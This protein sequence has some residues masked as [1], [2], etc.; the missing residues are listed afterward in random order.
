MENAYTDVPLI[1]SFYLP[2]SGGHRLYVEE[3]G[4]PQGQAVLFLHGGPG[5]AIN[6]DARTFFNPDKYRIILFDQRGCGRSQSFLSIEQNRPQDA[7]EDIESIRKYLNIKDWF[8]FGGSYGSTLALYYAIHFPERVSHLILR[9]IFLGRQED[10]DWLY[11]GGAGQYYPEE[12]QSFQ[13]AIGAESYDNLVENY[14][15][16]LLACKDNKLEFERLCLAWSRWESGLVKLKPD[17]L[18]GLHGSVSPG[19][20]SI[21]L[22]EA[23]YFA[24]HM[25]WDD[26]NY[27]LNHIQG[28][29]SIPTD[30]VHG[31][32]DID[33]RPIGA[34]LVAQK[35]KKANLYIVQDGS[36]SPYEEGMFN[37]LLSIMNSLV[38]D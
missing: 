26:D 31:R 11:H 10:I 36:H 37:H 32:F 5:G 1:Q 20:L 35:L 17:F 7:I 30:I 23:H 22:L 27:I 3:C 8:V 19:D 14:Y 16:E 18:E 29:E 34:Y 2:V 33:C 15:K 21:A 4:N 28:I 13:E 12:F 25:F 6:E 24:N 38:D 9:G